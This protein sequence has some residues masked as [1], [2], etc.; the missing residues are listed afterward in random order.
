MAK[1][2]VIQ[3]QKLIADYN[4]NL[5]DSTI[6]GM[7]YQI[8]PNIGHVAIYFYQQSMTIL[9]AQNFFRHH[10]SM[11]WKTV[12]GKPQKNWKVLAKDW[13]FNTIQQTKLFERQEAKRIAFPD[14]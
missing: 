6:Q 9:D 11:E 3:Q 12:S 13:I 5:A 7:G 2:R 8:P 4:D 10:E 1:R 14:T